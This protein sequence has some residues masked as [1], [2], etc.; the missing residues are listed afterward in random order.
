MT[1]PGGRSQQAS[2]VRRAA[3]EQ[4]GG[5]TTVRTVGGVVP[6]DLLARIVA[7]DDLPGLRADDYRLEL[8]VSPREAANRAW[9]V[10]T[11]A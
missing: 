8:G 7:G 2:T 5:L 4:L 9:S 3:A 10:L 6:P 1:G 11:G